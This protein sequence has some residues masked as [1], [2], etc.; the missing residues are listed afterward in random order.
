M[1]IFKRIKSPKNRSSKTRVHALETLP[2]LCTTLILRHDQI[3]L[4]TQ[5]LQYEP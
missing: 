5:A 2:Q 3:L 4:G 1:D